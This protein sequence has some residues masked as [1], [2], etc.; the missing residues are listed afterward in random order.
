MGQLYILDFT[1]R[2]VDITKSRKHRDGGSAL[3]W[4]AYNAT[5]SGLDHPKGP[6]GRFVDG[7]PSVG[8]L[9]DIPD[10]V[11]RLSDADLKRT[12]EQANSLIR[13]LTAEKGRRG[14]DAFAQAVAADKAKK[15]LKAT[16]RPKAAAKAIDP[17]L[18]SK[19]EQIKKRPLPGDRE[20]LEGALGKLTIAQIQS[21]DENPL[22]A[23]SKASKV[24]EMVRRLTRQLASEA[25]T[26]QGSAK[27]RD[28]DADYRSRLADAT[29]RG[30][31]DEYAA[32]VAGFGVGG[33]GPGLPPKKRED[34]LSRQMREDHAA[35]MSWRNPSQST[36][37]TQVNDLT[38]RIEAATD[39]ATKKRLKAERA[40]LAGEVMGKPA[41]AAKPL[42]ATKPAAKANDGSALTGSWMDGTFAADIDAVIKNPKAGS[43]ELLTAQLE[44]LKVAELGELAKKYDVKL[45]GRTKKEKIAGFVAST[46]QN[47]LNSQAIRDQTN[48]TPKPKTPTHL[49]TPRRTDGDGQFYG[50]HYHGDGQIGTVIEDFRP[51]QARINVGGKRLDDAL[52]DV[53]IRGH[54]GEAG[55]SAWQVQEF[56]RIANQVRSIDVDAADSIDRA[57]KKID[58]PRSFDSFQIDDFVTDNTP[59]PLAELMRVVDSAAANVFDP[60][61]E[62]KALAEMARK[63]DSGELRAMQLARDVEMFSPRRHESQE[64]F[65]EIRNAASRAGKALEAD[66][67]GLRARQGGRERVAAEIQSTR[68]ALEEARANLVSQ[69]GEDPDSW[70]EA[71]QDREVEAYYDLL[72]KL[73]RLGG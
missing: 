43:A 42:K 59:K 58:P 71:R 38:R 35:I 10:F 33:T 69:Y 18:T 37:E 30:D 44:R 64:G 47:K 67:K 54:G 70:P 40:A 31:R 11:H 50:D 20:F 32:L 22:P 45:L 55:I 52:A 4:R 1:K 12:D 3:D 7:H 53:I 34:P 8:I 57:V 17:A 68:N 41:P 24:E 39:P 46:V 25:V 48:F 65:F 2:G 26:H 16:A 23:G 9:G 21:L 28:Y 36:T 51:D 56:K 5:R 6:D 63:W 13:A 19:L 15:P 61:A 49:D 29:K 62:L 73:R 14:S 60:D 66:M 27:G 72:D